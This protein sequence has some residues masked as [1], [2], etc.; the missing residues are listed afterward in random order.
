MSEIKEITITNDKKDVKTIIDF[1]NKQYLTV[2][3]HLQNYLVEKS[4]G[5]LK[6]REY[7]ESQRGYVW[8]GW[9]ASNAIQSLIMFECP[10]PDITLYRFDD[11]SQFR[12]TLDGQQR[13]TAI[14]L[15]VDGAYTLDMSKTMFP[16]FSVEGIEHKAEDLHGK[17][18]SELPIEW[19]D[20]IL[21]N[22][23]TWRCYNNCTDEQAERLYVQMNGGAKALKAAEIR[24][25]AMGSKTRKALIRALSS[26]WT[27]HAMTAS[28]ASGNQGMEIMCHA[29]TL[30]ANGC[31]P[32]ELDKSTVDTTVYSYRESG[33][34]EAITDDLTG[35]NNLLNEVTALWIEDKKVA[36]AG[37]EKGKKISNYNTYRFPFLNKTHAVMLMIAAHFAIEKG[38]TEQAFASWAWAFFNT[39]TPKEYKNACGNN[40]GKAIEI[41]NVEERLNAILESLEAL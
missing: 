28:A 41:D 1:I 17:H 6:P 2:G 32:V 34:P 9:R 35:I 8:E 27:L 10:L 11:R 39:N 3:E 4:K 15:Y 18:F 24:K 20:R 38:I 29:V 14:Y 30:L 36:D 31:N 7:M 21:N 40:G 19:Q 25:G 37:R 16:V 5:T 23:I 22:S 13:Q 33:L 26:D 12:K